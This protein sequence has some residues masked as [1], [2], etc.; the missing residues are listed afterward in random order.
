MNNSVS[1]AS[2][3]V[4]EIQPPRPEDVKGIRSLGRPIVGN[5]I[6]FATGK[7][8]RSTPFKNQDLSWI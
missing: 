6:Y 1:N 3:V 2:C 7:H 5:A 4:H 8:V